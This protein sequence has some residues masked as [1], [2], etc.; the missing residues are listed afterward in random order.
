MGSIEELFGK[1]AAHVQI[2][3]IENLLKQEE[4][5]ALEYKRAQILNRP[6]DLSQSVSA[7]LNSNGG[8]IIIGVRQDRQTRSVKGKEARL[9]HQIE[10]VGAEYTKERVEQLIFD[11]LHF[12]SKPDIR[13]HPVKNPSEPDEALYLI[14]IPPGDDPPYQAGDF[15]YY[16]RSNFKKQPMPH[17]EIASC[18]GRR[19]SPQLT[20]S[21]EIVRVLET[22]QTKQFGKVATSDSPFDLRV[23]IKNYGKAAAE[24]SEVILS[25]EHL[26]LIKV[27]SGPDLRIDHLRQGMS[28]LQCSIPGVIL[29]E[30]SKLTT[31]IW[32]L[33]IK[34]DT[35]WVGSVLWEAYA[36]RMEPAKGKY[37]V[38]GMDAAQAVL[39]RGMRCFL[40]EHS[41]FFSTQ[42]SG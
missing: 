38:F 16:H 7:F 27:I 25:L 19:Q 20:V 10:F 12:S 31:C 29:G 22:R 11:H 3:D 14:E 24:H 40:L 33:R 30:P 18:F 17:S 28:T 26:K 37:V 15:R 1:S 8:L 32:E 5:H 36:E 35:N 34:P 6:D 2:E 13:I 4:C 21:C 41:S 42:P 23:Y 39:N 9:R